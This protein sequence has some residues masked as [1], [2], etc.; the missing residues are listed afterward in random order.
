MRF[1]E[2]W[3]RKLVNPPITTEV[4]VEQMTMAGLEIDSVTPAVAEFN[5]VVVGQVIEVK[6]HP[7]ADKL[8]LCTINVGTAELLQIVCGASNVQ[9]NMC[10]PTA[11]V[12]AVLPGNIKIKKT[13]LRGQ[14]SLGMLCS[15][16][17]LGIEDNVDGLMRL[18]DDAPVGKDIKDYL[19]L[20]DSLITV[21]LTPNRADCLSILGVA[22]E[23]A[24]LNKLNFSIPKRANIAISYNQQLAVTVKVPELCPR[25]LGRLIKG[26]NAKT[27]TPLWMRERLRRSG[28]RSLGILVDVTNYI[29]LEFGQPL[30]IFDAQKLTGN[31][32][33]RSGYQDEKLTLLNG[34]TITIDQTIMVI[35][36]QKQAIALAGVM[37][38]S[39]TAVT[40]QTTDIF[41]ECAFFAPTEI[42]GKARRFGLH[43]DSSH[44][45]ERGVD[46]ELQ[47]QA[48]DRATQF[49]L[50]I[51]GGS[52]GA[53]TE[54][55]NTQ[56][57]PNRKPILLRAKQ[58]NKILGFSMP[59]VEVQDMLQRLGMKVR[60]QDEGWQ[61]TSPSFRFDIAIEAD[62]IEEIARIYGYNNLP[63][64]TLLMRSE[65]AKAPE[66]SLE[67]DRIKDLL[68]ALEYQEV[69]TYSFIDQHM[70]KIIAPNGKFISLK[71]P[72]SSEL[73]VMRT[74]IWCGLLL[75]ASYNIRRQHSRIRLF[76]SG[77][78]FIKNNSSLKQE[79]MLAGLALGSVNNEQWG[80][81][82]KDI[83]FYDIKANVEALVV[84]RGYSVKFLPSDNP[85]LHPGQC[86]D[87]I[88]T[89]GEKLG[90]LG[91]LHPTLEK[92]LGF[93]CAVFLFELKQDL[94]TNKNMPAFK[95][96]P[97][98]PSVRRDIA[99]IID[100]NITIEAILEEIKQC[101]SRV[102]QDVVVF[103]VYH[104]QDIGAGKKSV[105]LGL[106]IQD[107]SQT[108]TD[109]KI[110]NIVNVV[111][112]K[113]ANN[114]NATLRQ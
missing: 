94:L 84:L 92:Q 86:A 77:L 10:V 39:S 83:D 18:A 50:E 48:L 98:F 26:V 58:I 66:M 42:M 99:L 82:L 11:L 31:I 113:L 45:F 27:P 29:L 103:D 17:E 80:E 34:K 108:L 97:K 3:L 37:G 38:G 105:A 91:M 52:A 59:V 102:L 78:C 95:P 24:V 28:V 85:A 69:I 55:S 62:L 73:E 79:K 56:N 64:T 90:C 35:A 53:I 104:A 12:G 54:V 36:D 25:Y 22:R 8:R 106:I 72:L 46:Y 81:K 71:N 87:V 6:T 107:F 93:D 111:L 15:A 101:N 32:Q 51:S 19:D 23:V 9:K 67:I 96:L 109:I 40:D 112:E 57:L 68:V 47:Q 13:K 2:T 44:R 100:E 110:D 88:T 21:D 30:H 61:V 63:K 75:A 4:L 5:G 16:Q 41:L 114:L 60:N 1:S 33:V 70:Q 74:T 49:I 14:L 89:E 43:T 76:E 65:L 20:N 7:N